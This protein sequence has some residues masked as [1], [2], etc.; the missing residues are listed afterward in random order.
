M[1]K[2]TTS[3][4]AKEFF[5]NLVT[6]LSP[7]AQ[8]CD[9]GWFIRNHITHACVNNYRKGRISTIKERLE[10]LKDRMTERR[11]GRFES[12]TL[13]KLFPKDWEIIRKLKP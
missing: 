5:E 12:T 7:E 10:W 4:K 13:A 9:I 3:D 8:K 2:K 6:Q 1:K 11:V